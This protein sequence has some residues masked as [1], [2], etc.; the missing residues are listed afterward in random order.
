[1]YLGND[2]SFDFSFFVI[3]SVSFDFGLS[4][5]LVVVAVTS[6]KEFWSISD[7]I[8]GQYGVVPAKIS[9]FYI[10]YKFSYII[11]TKILINLQKSWLFAVALLDQGWSRRFP[12]KRNFLNSRLQRA[13]RETHS[14]KEFLPANLLLVGLL[15]LKI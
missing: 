12:Q 15:E 8:A 6:E 13:N 10:N 1:M 5:S 3:R 2:S 7:C 11:N 4:S 9:Y 14:V